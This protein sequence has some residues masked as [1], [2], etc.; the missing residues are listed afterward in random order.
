MCT[1]FS[2]KLSC[3]CFDILS[4][5]FNYIA[6]F[7]LS[8]FHLFGMLEGLLIASRGSSSGLCLDRSNQ[9][10]HACKKIVWGTMFFLGL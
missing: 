4:K 9:F 8:I 6:F 10:W 2:E 5:I 7:L 3:A 1:N